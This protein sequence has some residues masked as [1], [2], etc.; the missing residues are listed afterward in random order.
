MKG[1]E[2][3][4]ER[5]SVLY[6]QGIP[7]NVS[8]SDLQGALQLLLKIDEKVSCQINWLND[9][10]SAFI[11]FEQSERAVDLLKC[12]NESESVSV[13]IS[14]NP[15]ASGIASPN[16]NTPSTMTTSKASNILSKIKLFTYKQYQEIRDQNTAAESES[17]DNLNRKRVKQIN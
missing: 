10:S 8:V 14:P 2:I 16:I 17:R 3:E 6:V 15:S 12:Q 11:Q 1:Q 13:S 5:S 4:P 7:G 9:S